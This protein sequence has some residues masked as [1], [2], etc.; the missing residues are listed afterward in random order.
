MSGYPSNEYP[1]YRYEDNRAPPRQELLPF[2]LS[3]DGIKRQ[4]I[5]TDIPRYLGNNAYSRPGH[6][7]GVEG[8]W[9]FGYRP[10][11]DAQVQSLKVDSQKWSNERELMSRHYPNRDIGYTSSATFRDS[12]QI[13]PDGNN[14]NHPYPSVPPPNPAPPPTNYPP[15]GSTSTY[16]HP[17]TPY[18]TQQAPPPAGGIPPGG[19][20]RRYEFV[21]LAEGGKWYDH[22]LKQWVVQPYGAPEGAPAPV[23][24]PPREEPQPGGPDEPD[25]PYPPRTGPE[26]QPYYPPQG[27]YFPRT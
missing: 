10:L 19:S 5:Q 26:T 24:R 18:G 4:V 21:P 2:F 14:P 20:N 23:P 16:P 7:Q 22:E 1:G 13:N 15:Y 17:T 6:N 11:T 27:P 8:Y 25:T 9:Y 3:G 12:H